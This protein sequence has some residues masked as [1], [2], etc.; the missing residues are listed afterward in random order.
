MFTREAIAEHSRMIEITD[1]PLVT[2]ALFAYNQEHYIREAVEGALAQTYEPLEIIL[3]DDCSTDRTFEMMQEMVAAYEGPHKV[4]LNRNDENLKLIPHINRTA[5]LFSG[6]I[7]ILAAGDD[8]SHPSR[9]AILSEVFLTHP[10]AYAVFSGITQN[11]VFKSNRIEPLSGREVRAIEI[12][13]N[14]GGIGPGASYAYRRDVFHWGGDIP[15][16]LLSEDKFLP[17]RSVI[18]GSVVKIDKE[19]VFYRAPEGSLT[20]SLRGSNE[21]ARLRLEHWRAL[22]ELINYGAVSGQLSDSRRKLHLFVLRT[23]KKVQAETSNISSRA[24]FLI[25]RII[26]KLT[27]LSQRKPKVPKS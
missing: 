3:S 1:R 10:N 23:S 4:V 21:F 25:L 18:L 7:V 5:K 27:R 6:D 19:L 20:K 12:L 16:S 9:T 24:S 22:E 2:F 14:A 17:T 8:V 26:R 15:E 13:M 11:K